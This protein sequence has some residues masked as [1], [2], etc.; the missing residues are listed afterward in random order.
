MAFVQFPGESD[1]VQLFDLGEAEPIDRFI[2]EFRAGIIGESEQDA[3]RDMVRAKTLGVPM[4]EDRAGRALRA[5]VFDPFAGALAGRK[6]IFLGPDGD[7]SLLPFEVLPTDDGRRLIDDY[8]ISYLACGRD[9]LRFQLPSTGQ[10]AEAVVAADPDFDLQSEGKAAPAPIDPIPGRHSR[11]LEQA[12]LSFDRLPGT[13]EEG[14]RIA[15]LLKVRPWLQEEV[16]EERLKQVRSPWVLHLATHGFFLP[17]RRDESIENHSWSASSDLGRFSGL[18]LENPLLRSGLALAGGN[19]WL[20]KG[21]LPREA[22]D[23]LLTAEDVVGMDLLDTELVVLSACNTGL[24]EIRT[25]EGVYGLRRAFVLAGAKT[26]IMS[27][28]KVPDEPTRE[29]MEG[30][31]R[32]ILAGQGRA[33]ALREAQ[34]AL[35]AKYPEPFYWGAFICQGDP[36]PLTRQS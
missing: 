18:K 10:S 30:F 2:A 16:L 7:L 23:G 34:L 25:G 28:W 4:A 17:D 8:C 19:T 20:N 13:R 14:V 26:L 31:Y 36:G 24:G 35:K 3:N 33:Q 6:G 15:C 1:N 21:H 27:L 29:L 11:D 5:A 32:R 22:E 12:E 9:V